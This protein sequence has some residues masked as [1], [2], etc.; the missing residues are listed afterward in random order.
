MKNKIY[1]IL[2]ARGLNKEICPYCLQKQLI[3]VECPHARY[4]LRVI[5][6]QQ[7]NEPEQKDE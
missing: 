6:K 1:Q 5:E 7:D 4:L 3:C 2:C